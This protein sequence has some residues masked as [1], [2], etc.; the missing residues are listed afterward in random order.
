LV[1]PHTTPHCKGNQ[2]VDRDHFGAHH[3]DRT[4]YLPAS[5]FWASQKV[6]YCQ[7]LISW[8]CVL[9]V[10][11]FAKGF[12][13]VVSDGC[14]CLGRCV[15]KQPACLCTCV[16]AVYSRYHMQWPSGNW[17]LWNACNYL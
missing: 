12:D 2:V 15:W 1:L 6:L 3:A 4:R 11:L 14:E 5:V 8:L 9:D 13:A 10:G 17:N 7:S 16:I